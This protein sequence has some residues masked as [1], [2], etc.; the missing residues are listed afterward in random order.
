MYRLDERQ[1]IKPILPDHSHVS[2]R[3]DLPQAYA[4]NGAVYVARRDWIMT[5]D[6]FRGPNTVGNVM[7]KERSTDI[8]DELD[9]VLAEFL[10]Q[11]SVESEQPAPR[12]RDGLQ[13]TS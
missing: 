1:G 8:D 11:R 6:G 9:L 13:S 7:P 5:H 4:I 3:Q 2:R 12:H 10:D